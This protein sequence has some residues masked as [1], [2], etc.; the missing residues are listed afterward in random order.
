MT[1]SDHTASGT[2]AATTWNGKIS[3]IQG[4]RVVMIVLIFL[5]HVDFELMGVD[6]SWKVTF[7]DFANGFF[8]IITGF[9]LAHTYGP[10]IED[11]SYR[12]KVF[13]GKRLKKIY[14][15]YLLCA[16]LGL[17][18]RFPQGLH[19][20]LCSIPSLFMVQSWVPDIDIFYG[21]NSPLWFVSTLLFIWAVFPWIYKASKRWWA[22]TIMA[23]LYLST[24]LLLDSERNLKVIE[25]FPLWRIPDILIGILSYRIAKTLITRKIANKTK[26]R[27]LR[28]KT[29][30]RELT[31]KPISR[32]LAGKTDSRELA[33]KP[34]SRGLANVLLLVAISI[35]AL[36]VF[37]YDDIPAQP[38]ISAIYWLVTPLALIST[39]AGCTVLNPVLS[40]RL[41]LTLGSYTMYFYLIH[42]VALGLA[43]SIYRHIALPVWTFLPLCISL[44]LL[45]AYCLARLDRSFRKKG[46]N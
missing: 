36:T 9:V 31:G 8:F 13:L 46:K 11:G 43:S 28:C 34:I 3:A 42:F 44:S 35:F 4:W 16:I 6:A 26:N 27:E 1:A 12:H 22:V 33:G 37:F 45:A 38:R 7:G 41:M 19:A 23:T 32:E 39:T 24:F 40:N 10:D 2:T 20:V 29:D 25:V 17:L 5:N 30:S 21:G 14:P 15:A 18:L